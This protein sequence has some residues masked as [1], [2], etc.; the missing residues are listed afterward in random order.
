MDGLVGGAYLSL[1]FLIVLICYENVSGWLWVK[2]NIIIHYYKS[3]V[4][5]E[6]KKKNT[7]SIWS[8][9]KIRMYFQIQALS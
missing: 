7:L 5:F 9:K 1:S 4:L 6:K 2:F 3:E 8:I